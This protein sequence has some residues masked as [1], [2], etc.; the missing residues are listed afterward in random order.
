MENFGLWGAIVNALA[1]IGGSLAG[2][3]I[4]YI[5]ARGG[6]ESRIKARSAA[7]FRARS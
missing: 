6:H 7:S 1:V 5:T 4:H 3:I 2:V